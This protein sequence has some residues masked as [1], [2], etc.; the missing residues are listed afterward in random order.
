M[1][2]AD[3]V[4]VSVG[5]LVGVLVGVS[6]G[7][8]V[9]VFVGVSVGVDVGVLVG[10]DVGVF[11]LVGVGVS[12]DVGVGEGSLRLVFSLPE[13]LAPLASGVVEVNDAVSTAGAA[14]VLAV[15][16]TLTVL[17][18][19]PT[20]TPSAQVYSPIGGAVLTQPPSSDT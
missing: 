17:L 13:L 12:V 20:T 3:P 10:V 11:V 8:L 14:E 9:G 7:V 2:V 6:V 15:T 18:A 1:G 4:G 16:V 5:V 19:P